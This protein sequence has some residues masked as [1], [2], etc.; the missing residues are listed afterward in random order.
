[1]YVGPIN[2]SQKSSASETQKRLPADKAINLKEENVEKPVKEPDSSHVKALVADVQNKLNDVDLHFSVN[3]SSGTI[4]VTVTEES[5]GKVIREIPSS[6]SL[7][8][9]A[10]MDEMSGLLFDKKG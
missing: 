7:Q 8:L 4:M 9:A 6:E 2:I 3:Q 1:M 5:S 10:K